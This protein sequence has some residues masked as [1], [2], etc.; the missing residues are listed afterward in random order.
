MPETSAVRDLSEKLEGVVKALHDN[1]YQVL[2]YDSIGDAVAAV[3]RNKRVEGLLQ[4]EVG[5]LRGLLLAVW[6][7]D[8]SEEQQAEVTRISVEA[9][10][11]ERTSSTTRSKRVLRLKEART[12][13]DRA[14]MDVVKYDYVYITS[15]NVGTSDR[16]LAAH[17]R[18]ARAVDAF[19]A[20]CSV[21]AKVSERTMPETRE[22]PAIGDKM[23]WRG[24]SKR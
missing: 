14:K 5:R 2:G 18:F 8:A 13:L 24:W 15:P 22:D 16:S 4:A 23:A 7:G 12:A 1:G 3:I 17:E 6:G 9:A 21:E 10:Q 19:A 11:E 20:A